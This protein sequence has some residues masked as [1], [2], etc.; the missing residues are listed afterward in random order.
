[1][2][3]C[4]Q[5]PPAHGS[6]SSDPFAGSIWGLPASGTVS[7]EANT[8]SETFDHQKLAESLSEATGKTYT[9]DDL[10][11]DAFDYLA[12]RDFDLLIVPNANHHLGNNRYVIRK[13]WE[14]FVRNLLG[15]NPPREYTIKEFD[16]N[17]NP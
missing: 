16:S 8:R 13:R 4:Y 7:P 9:P 12:N 17:S 11:F 5:H 1:M 2:H 15:V 14:Y 3:R 10:P 6:P